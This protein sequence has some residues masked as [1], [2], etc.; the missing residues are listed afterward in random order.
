[1]IKAIVFDLDGT[2]F[3]RDR[4]IQHVVSAQYHT[5]LPALAHVPESTFVSRFIILDNHGHVSKDLVYRT[6]VEEFAIT[7]V[8]ATTLYE[9]FVSEYHTHCV[10]CPSLVETLDQLH[11]YGLRLGIITNGTALLQL[12]TVRALKIEHYFSAILISEAEGMRKPERAIFQRALDLLGI[13]A[14][15]CAFVGDHPLVDVEG[16]YA[17]GLK[18]IWKRTSVWA[19]PR[20]ADGVIDDLI[21]LPGVIERLN[22]G[23]E[24]TFV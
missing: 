2:L 22:G 19:S 13:T 15:E 12:N 24:N 11:A 1:M 7:E 16:A 8:T 6:L 20:V 21:E 4:S 9:H 3:D 17:A 14:A 18:A 10:A 23:N 5:Y